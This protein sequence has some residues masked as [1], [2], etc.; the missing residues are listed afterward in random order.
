MFLTL[1]MSSAHRRTGEIEVQILELCLDGVGKTFIVY[2]LNLNFAAGNRHLK[3]LL[4]KGLIE[5]IQ[6][7]RPIYKTTQKG[8]SVLRHIWKIKEIINNSD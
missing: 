1:S 7:A 2:S 3:S 6:G 8:K 5:V 4:D